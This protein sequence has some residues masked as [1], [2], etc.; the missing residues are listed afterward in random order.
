M[1]STPKE[2]P[3]ILRLIVGNYGNDDVD[4]EH[5]DDGDK[6]INNNNNDI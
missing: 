6:N 2:P 1:Q 4:K 5:V 3:Q